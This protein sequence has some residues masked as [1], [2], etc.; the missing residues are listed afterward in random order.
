MLYTPEASTKP[1]SSL[2]FRLHQLTKN[3]TTS[4]RP[5]RIVTLVWPALSIE[6]LST[7]GP[8]MWRVAAGMP[9]SFV[10]TSWIVSMAPWR[11]ARAVSESVRTRHVW[12]S[13]GSSGSGSPVAD[14][15]GAPM[16]APVRRSIASSRS[17]LSGSAIIKS[18]ARGP[19]W[20][21][22]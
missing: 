9:H 21:D 5:K 15:G 2:L 17:R 8:P 13:S 12:R 20:A 3:P 10:A 16:I 1:T 7:G 11:L 22:L 4:E 6:T 14:F 18:T 19:V